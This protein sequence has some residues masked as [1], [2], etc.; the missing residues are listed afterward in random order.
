MPDSGHRFAIETN[1]RHRVERWTRRAPLSHRSRIFLEPLRVLIDGPL[2][3]RN[4]VALV[5]AL[6]PS[7][8]SF[9]GVGN[10]LTVHGGGD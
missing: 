10:R 6:D 3:G 2:Q 1:N 9:E 8:Q 4:A 5:A 7:R